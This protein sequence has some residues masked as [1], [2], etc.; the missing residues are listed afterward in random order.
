M[1]N[2]NIYAITVQAQDIEP[3]QA[4]LVNYDGVAPWIG[5]MINKVTVDGDRV[6]FN[7]VNGGE[8]VRKVGEWVTVVDV[9]S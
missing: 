6:T 7:T 2:D 5:P 3:G 4:L 9:L 8:G 1:S